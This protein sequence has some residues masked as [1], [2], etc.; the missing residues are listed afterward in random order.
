M[1]SIERASLF[2]PRHVES[3]RTRDRTHVPCIDRWILNHWTTRGIE[4]YLLEGRYH[5]LIKLRFPVPGMASGPYG[6]LEFVTET[7]F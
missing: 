1:G 2:A 3:S 5:A 4:D 6:A 7:T